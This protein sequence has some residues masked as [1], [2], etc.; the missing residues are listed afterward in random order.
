MA[1]W[2]KLISGSCR[3]LGRFI[4]L[5]QSIFAL[6]FLTSMTNISS[7]LPISMRFV[8]HI[9]NTFILIGDRIA[10]RLFSILGYFLL[11]VV[12]I[13]IAF[14][15]YT[16][17]TAVLPFL[18]YQ[19]GPDSYTYSFVKFFACWGIFKLYFHYFA[20]FLLGPGHPPLASSVSSRA[21]QR[22][23]PAPSI[24]KT[25]GPSSAST[26]LSPTSSTLSLPSF[27]SSIN[28]TDLSLPPLHSRPTS[29]SH[30]CPSTP[31]L[32]TSPSSLSTIHSPATSSSISPVTTTPVTTPLSSF[33]HVLGQPLSSLP[34]CHKC[35]RVKP[36]RTHHCSICRTC[37]LKMD[38]H[39]P[40]FNGCV[41]YRN[42][43]HFF[44]F[45]VTLWIMTVFYL[46]FA[47]I[48]IG[49]A[50]VS[51]HL[52]YRPE[53][54]S[55]RTPTTD[56][57][58]PSSSSSSSLP[59]TSPF[60][61]SP[62]DPSLSP[63]LDD[64]GSSPS[65]LSA[66]GL[67]ASVATMVSNMRSFLR[68]ATEDVDYT[69][70]SAISATFTALSP[71]SLIKYNSGSTPFAL[72][73][74]RTNDPNAPDDVSTPFP[75]SVN[76]FGPSLAILRHQQFRSN[77]RILVLSFVLSVSACAAMFLFVAWNIYLI[78]AALTTIEVYD[79][80]WPLPPKKSNLLPPPPPPPTNTASTT[81]SS[82]VPSSSLS[83]S[84]SSSAS[85]SLAVSVP[86]S[87]TNQTNPICAPSTLRNENNP[88]PI[89]PSQNGY[90]DQDTYID[91]DNSSASESTPLQ[92]SITSPTS[93]SSTTTTT[94]S[95]P[96]A[97]SSPSS[98]S[99]SSSSPVHT[100][101]GHNWFDRGLAHN[102][103]QVFGK[104]HFLYALIIPDLLQPEGDGMSFLVSPPP[105]PPPR[106]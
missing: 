65:K 35:N 68:S 93:S 36:P 20:A 38:H 15:A 29:P 71:S 25:D 88:T 101:S 55:L 45:L 47:S 27:E 48:P 44:M 70:D 23:S 60:P 92:I 32:P 16:F 85:S 3:L 59:S 72:T 91:N 56:A 62:H 63:P 73:S 34:I 66:A 11:V 81:P 89:S 80:L 82:T 103:R 106:R 5:S 104:T 98:S 97:S 28:A 69:Q 14:V 67:S 78:F 84:A 13:A 87:P 57:F 9:G 79:R 50:M 31:S 83:S 100:V 43:A 42:H 75:Q 1:G 49:R 17:F 53:Y 58:Q 90:V 21:I 4:I 74:P 37:V 30:S 7:F 39:C 76:P 8:I 12:Q 54:P 102:Y 96:L 2:M 46:Y 40:W 24:N 61:S 94:T 41:G 18:A 105:P 86:V 10:D 6:L 95:T 33:T 51:D 26:P 22:S 77:K 19:Y 99:S 64:A 52:W